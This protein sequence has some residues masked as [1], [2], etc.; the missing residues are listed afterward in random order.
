MASGSYELE[1][2]FAAGKV[3]LDTSSLYFDALHLAG[4]T[5][6]KLAHFEH[7]IRFYRPVATSLLAVSLSPYVPG[8][9]RSPALPRSCTFLALLYL[10][11][12]INNK[13]RFDS[14]CG[15]FLIGYRQLLIDDLLKNGCGL[16]T[17]DKG[18][19]DEKRGC[20]YNTAVV[21]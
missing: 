8:A 3:N 6:P 9:I 2:R 16:G 17:A 12:Q 20:A 4:L 21:S 19:S 13:Q 15:A 10:G 11:I 1:G 5:G 18:T 7:R 14:V